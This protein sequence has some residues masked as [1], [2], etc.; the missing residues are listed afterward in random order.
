MYGIWQFRLPKEIVQR[1]IDGL[2]RLG[3]KI[4]TNSVVG[5]MV[6]IDELMNEEGY[7]AVFIGSGA[8]CLP[9]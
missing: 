7:K 8:A 6:S 1:E 2:K 3:V 4:E 5:K 9:L